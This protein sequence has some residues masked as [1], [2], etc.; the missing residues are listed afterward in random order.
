MKQVDQFDG[1]QGR[2]RS[3]VAGF[4]PGAFD[5]LLQGVG[6]YHSEGRGHPGRKPHVGDALC[7]FACDVLKMRRLPADYA[8]HADDGVELSAL[9]QFLG[10]KG[11]LERPRYVYTGNVV[12]LAPVPLKRVDR[13]GELFRGN[14]VIH[15][16]DDNSETTTGGGEL[17]VNIQHSKPTK[18][19]STQRTLLPGDPDFQRVLASSQ[20]LICELFTL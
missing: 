10:D 7:R 20:S 13:A 12:I 15:P 18:V 3:L 16:A 8:T 5:R 2:V 6:G 17:S 4:G 1:A 19:S 14:E 9:R 11:Q